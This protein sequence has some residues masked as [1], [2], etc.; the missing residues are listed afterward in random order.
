MLATQSDA[1][2]ALHRVTFVEQLA[3]H[4]R[5]PAIHHDGQELTYLDLA[6][7]VAQRAVELGTPR[8]LVHIA[9]SND[10]ETVLTYLGALRAGH[11]V[12]MT[13]PGD[14]GGHRIADPYR[15]AVRAHRESGGWTVERADA[16]DGPGPEL[17]PDLA[18]L[19][20][21]SGSTGSPK[22]V[23]LSHRTLD[24]NAAAIADYLDITRSDV[25][26]TS[27]PLHYCY[28]LSVLHSHLAAGASIVLTTNS[29]VDPCFWEAVS[30]HS[31]SS[32]AGVPH[33][34][35]LLER[36]G[37][38]E[39]ELPSL[40]LLTQAGGHMEAER[41]RHFARMG[42][43]AGWELCV[44][45]GQTEATARMAY[46]PPELAIE[47]AG[48]VG[49]AV[50]GGELR[51][52]PFEGCEPGTGEVVYSGPNVMMGYAHGA[53]DLA[54]GPELGE[55]RTGDIGLLAR[56][57]LLEIRGRLGRFAKV[58][59]LRVD[60]DEVER[61]LH[62]ESIEALCAESRGSIALATTGDA[63]RARALVAERTGVPQRAV[64]AEHVQQLPRTANGKPDRSGLRSRGRDH[65]TCEP[66]RTSDLRDVLGRCMG[67]DRIR[68]EDTF[69]SLGGD[70]LSY[71]EVS[72]AVERTLG[73]LPPGWHLRTVGELER[74]GTTRRR[75]A[76]VDTTVVIRAVAILLVVGSHA[77]L[78]R[79]RGGA[80]LLLVVAGF[81][82]ARFGLGARRGSDLLASTAR[83]LGRVV[84]PSALW[85]GGLTLLGGGYG[86]ASIALVNSYLG[87][88]HWDP[89]W[90]YWFVEAL[91]I[92]TLLTVALLALGP[93]RRLAQ[94][95]PFAIPVGLLG[96]GLVLRFD[97]LSIP[98]TVEPL[99]A[100]HR[101]LWLFALGL[102]IERC[103]TP[104]QRLR[105]ERRGRAGPGRVLPRRTPASPGG[106]S[107][108]GHGP[109]APDARA[110]AV[111][112][113]TPLPA[114]GGFAVCLPDA[115]RGLP[116]P[117]GRGR[118]PRRGHPRIV[119]RRD[120]V[121][122]AGGAG[123]A[124]DP[125]RIS[126]AA[127]P[128]RC[129]AHVASGVSAEIL[130]AAAATAEPCRRPGSGPSRSSGPETESAA[131]TSPFP[132]VTG[133]DTLA[134]PGSRSSTEAT[135]GTW[136]SAVADRTWP[137]EP[138]S[139][140]SAAPTGTIVRSPWGD[141]SA[142]TQ[143]RSAPS[144]T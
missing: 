75:L 15:P 61:H 138:L 50:P 27:L 8:S 2:P 107:G 119:P 44:M 135:Q 118:T 47:R 117:P 11:V 97:V 58:F 91:V 78:F 40:R 30:T 123:V 76:R 39:M 46:L 134:T 49:V 66:D 125:R 36:A 121:L 108:N 139:M 124:L 59:G 14:R 12:L 60:L 25:G 62:G 83:S 99:L 87:P 28:G 13:P 82:L 133:A 34:F 37:I 142:A 79:L 35:E 88:R 68:S 144:V 5:R 6:E 64:S 16:T 86:L 31:V 103:R 140:G 110:A 72:T 104:A 128:G 95:R 120:R 113:A 141:S 9:G 3:S 105:G 56:D 69:V 90:R 70:S 20:S 130:R 18:L 45:Y 53:A 80:H 32:I 85:L 7:L 109:L 96:L 84:V 51:I 1:P 115:L 112:G 106:R 26:I 98:G 143:T 21:T 81:N 71:V 52:E 54:K 42:A 67:V 114:R 93:V 102:T 74:M 55:L 29:V 24:S 122:A 63:D 48:A 38:G 73:Q 77:S 127:D 132:S 136:L 92:A 129:R 17:H 65:G 100:P 19:L 57:G 22:C 126:G 101:V 137:A 111:R 33:T 4:G 131:T 94:R 43:R 41:V 89:A 23:R 10:L 116:R